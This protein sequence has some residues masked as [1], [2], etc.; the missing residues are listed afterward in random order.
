LAE[1]R[2]VSEVP[3]AR[4]LVVRSIPPGAFMSLDEA[5]GKIRDFHP[6]VMILPE[7]LLAAL[8][9]CGIMVLRTESR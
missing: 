5:L 8:S 9:E 1:T 4:A 7:T 3:E 6:R 2:F